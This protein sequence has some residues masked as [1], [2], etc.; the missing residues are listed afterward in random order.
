MHLVLHSTTKTS[1]TEASADNLNK[2]EATTLL[3]VANNTV[4]PNLG[5]VDLKEDTVDL[6]ADTVDLRVDM[7]GLRVGMV[8]LKE[9]MVDPRADMEDPLRD[10]LSSNSP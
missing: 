7:V 9:D 4:D 2:A 3:L 6:R 8:G 1:Q 5:M 10:T